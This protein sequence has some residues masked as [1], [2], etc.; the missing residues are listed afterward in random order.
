MSAELVIRSMMSS[1]N[2]RAEL[3]CPLK[4]NETGRSDGAVAQG[5]GALWVDSLNLYGKFM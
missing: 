5:T 3:L 4:C 2:V 1:Q